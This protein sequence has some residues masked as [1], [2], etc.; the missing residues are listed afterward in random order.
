MFCHG[1]VTML[2]T[3]F[4]DNAQYLLLDVGLLAMAGGWPT[5]DMG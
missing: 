1:F 3:G 5:D 2:S 4:G